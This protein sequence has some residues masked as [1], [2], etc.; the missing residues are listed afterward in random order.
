MSS[1]QYME[2]NYNSENNLFGESTE[3]RK[4]ENIK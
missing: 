2:I 1:W 3:N 4:N